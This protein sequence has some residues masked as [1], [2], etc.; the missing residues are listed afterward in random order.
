MEQKSSQ[1][2]YLEQ[3]L[4]EQKE[5]DRKLQ[6]RPASAPMAMEAIAQSNV[7]AGNVAPTPHIGK[8][9]EYR[10]TGF[11][12][13][14]SVVVP[15]NVYVVHTRRGHSQPIHIGRGISFRFNPL[16]DAFLIIPSAV[17]TILINANCIC[18]ERQGILV[19]AYVQWI[20]EDIRIAYWKLDFSDPEDPMGIVNIQLREQAEAAIKD[21]VATMSID[22]V[23][24]DKQP[25]IEELTHRLR[26]VAEGVSNDEVTSEGLGLKIV[27]IQIKEAVV[28]S[29]QLWENLQLPFRA[30]RKKLARLA[31]L[32]NQEEINNK[33]LENKLVKERAELNAQSELDILRATQEQT[34]Y[35]REHSE[36]LRR[37]TLEEE[38][39]RQKLSEKNT[40]LQA[41]NTAQLELVLQEL[42]LEKRRITAERE[43]VSAQILL[44]EIQRQK[45]KAQMTGEI[46]INQMQNI[47]NFEQKQRE[48]TIEQQTKEIENNISAQNIEAQLIAKLPEIAKNLPAPDQQQT[49]IITTENQDITMN[50]V[51]SFIS[52]VLSL[53]KSPKIEDKTD[54]S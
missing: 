2:T 11:G 35:N 18:I 24:S 28:S 39:E 23:L 52:S 7:F 1:N 8:A 17:Q 20:I 43:K 41:K 6:K 50:T 32:K 45:V 21:K 15:P 33:E 9:V 49:T 13:W 42:E 34:K 22:E 19:Q 46:D 25:I 29:T 54:I 44:D 5:V 10:I 36:I 4:Q 26:N 37:H 16:T 40:T 27:T 48:L 53:I 14:K 47:A 30:E 3:V 31:E 51:L 12:L 38:G